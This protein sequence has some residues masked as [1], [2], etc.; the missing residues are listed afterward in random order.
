MKTPRL[1]IFLLIAVLCCAFQGWS[2]AD[3][4]TPQY[5]F[6][7]DLNHLEDDK[8]TVI[9]TPQGFTASELIF[10]LPKAVPGIYGAMD[11]GQY[12]TNLKAEDAE[13][14]ALTITKL[15]V[16][17][18]KIGEAT[19]LA[20]LSYQ[21][22]DTWESF[23]FDH[24]QGF[25]CSASSGFTEE[26]FVLSQNSLFGYFEG[27]A[28]Q[29]VYLKVNRPE[30]FYGA[31]S[32]EGRIGEDGQDEFWAEDYHALVDNPMMYSR[33]DT[34]LLNLG[35]IEV[36]VACYSASHPDLSKA[37]AEHIKPLLI[38]QRQYLGGTLPVDHY[39]FIIYHNLNP[40]HYS[41]MG[42]GL[43]HSHSTLILLYMPDDVDVIKQNI[44]GIASHEFF[45]TVMPL[46]LHSHEIANYDFNHPKLSRH[47]WL[48][49]GMTE[50]FTI[51]MPIKNGVQ[52][53]DEFCHE[54]EEKY[55]QM[56]EFDPNLPL[57]ELSLNA[58]DMQDQYYNVYLR[59]S[60]LNL[61]LDIKLRELSEGSYGVQNLIADLLAKYG[62]DKPFEDEALFQEI[63]KITG[64]RELEGFIADYIEG[65]QPLPLKSALLAAGFDFDEEKKTVTV[66]ADPT[67]EQLALRKAWIDQ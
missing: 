10:C 39:T 28:R 5:H 14:K 56:Q 23:D 44:Y 21:V 61:C 62:A 64:Y 45:H 42:D 15:D 63:V 6:S 54:I 55:K 7:V 11:F 22:D 48:Y 40:D 36:E 57:T 66:I 31:T 27:F 1:S 53:M 8:L 51:H 58:I 67:E 2:Q 26:A 37:I 41:Y 16:N 9:L 12:I 50:Y 52:S 35:D 59:G 3:S 17:R 49:E 32:L 13:G 24:A 25:Y 29:P 18:W 20:R 60:L 38:N 34:T 19:Q 30:S 65:A 47:L 4:I 33:A 46:G 43:E